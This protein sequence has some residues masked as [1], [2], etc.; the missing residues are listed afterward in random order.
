[1][2]GLI[3]F[4]EIFFAYSETLNMCRKEEQQNDYINI[5]TVVPGTRYSDVLPY[6]R[7]QGNR[8]CILRRGHH[9]SNIN[10]LLAGETDPVL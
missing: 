5:Y 1:M 6:N 2:L 10:N 8:H 7:I 4:C 3:S 9:R